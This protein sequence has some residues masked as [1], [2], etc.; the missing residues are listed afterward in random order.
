M[1]QEKKFDE[2]VSVDELF[3]KLEGQ[4]PSENLAQFAK[5][6]KQ[7]RANANLIVSVYPENGIEACEHLVAA[8][9]VLCQK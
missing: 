3:D 9:F 4:S 7:F 1:N 5:F 8:L 6:R 2:R